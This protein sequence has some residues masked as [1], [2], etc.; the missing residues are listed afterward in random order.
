LYYYLVRR[1]DPFHMWLLV[2][3]VAVMVAAVGAAVSGVDMTVCLCLLM[4]A[5]VVTV[6]GYEWRGHRHEA[7][8]LG[9]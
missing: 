4:L 1:F 6:I 8:S 7:A 2:A 9:N 3:T 5:P